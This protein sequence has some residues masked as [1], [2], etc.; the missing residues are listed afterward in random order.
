MDEMQTPERRSGLAEA[1]TEGIL[2]ALTIRFPRPLKFC[3][4]EHASITLREPCV[5]E[6]VRAMDR[7]TVYEQMQALI[8]AVSGVPVGALGA[9]PASAYRA[10]EAFLMRFLARGDRGDEGLD[11]DAEQLVLR[12]A[13]PITV[14]AVQ[15]DRLVVTEPTLSMLTMA[16]KAG[17]TLAQD[18]QL[19]AQ[20]SL[21]SGGTPELVEKMRFSDFARA[22][23]FLAGF[24]A[25][26]ALTS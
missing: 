1:A 22:R 23:S 4:I 20:A 10:A 21:T 9:M 8:S 25:A 18:V 3:E 17:S 6:V 11:E 12:F 5:G 2:Q 7:G 13:E 14:G 26:S 24:T 19:L 16:A 15:R